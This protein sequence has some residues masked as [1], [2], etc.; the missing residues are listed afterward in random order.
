MK[1]R[2]DHGKMVNV[3]NKLQNESSM[4][5]NE[6]VVIEKNIEELKLVWQ[7][8][9]ADIFYIKMN[10]YLNKLKTIPT[11][12]NNMANYLE[13]TNKRY[14]EADLFLKKEIENVRMNG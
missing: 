5:L 1:I 10:N 14:K 13:K 8:E 2:I 4:L 12:Y 9:D 11:T 3:T 7:G 6:I